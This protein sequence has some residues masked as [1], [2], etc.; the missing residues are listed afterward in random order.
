MTVT[1]SELNSF[2][3]TYLTTYQ[4]ELENIT[5]NM[6]TVNPAVVLS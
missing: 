6:L 5:G 4:N 2:Y 3:L 1:Q